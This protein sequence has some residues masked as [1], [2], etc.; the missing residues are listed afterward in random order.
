[1]VELL[2][3]NLDAIV[4]GVV[5]LLGAIVGALVVVTTNRSQIRKGVYTDY[6]KQWSYRVIDAATALGATVNA[7]AESLSDVA[8]PFSGPG[9]RGAATSLLL[10][11]SHHQH[12]PDA[13]TEVREAAEKLG[14]RRGTPH[15]IEKLQA[16][17]V[18]DVCAKLREVADTNQLDVATLRYVMQRLSVVLDAEWEL[19]RHA[20]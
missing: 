4:T 2:A 9:P 17:F 20:E 16:P 11:L 1:M 14:K 18:A 19:A 3:A 7:S 8:G 13:D 6:R 12:L 10:L 15:A 5:G